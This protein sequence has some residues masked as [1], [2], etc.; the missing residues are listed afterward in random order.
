[1]KMGSG[2]NGARTCSFE[3]AAN[4]LQRSKRTVHTYVNQGF[5]RRITENGKVVLLLEDVEQLAVE[6]GTDTPALNRKTFF[7]LS[8]RVKKLEDEMNAVKH[9]LEI[10]DAPLRPSEL[11]AK[12]LYAAAAE[13]LGRRKWSID[14]MR[15]WAE[16]FERMDEVTLDTFRE[17]LGEPKPWQ[18]FYE[19]CLEMMKT[20]SSETSL[21]CMALHRKLDE[22]R[23]KMR[24]TI[25]MWIE[26]GRGSIP[27]NVFRLIDS[28]KESVLRKVSQ[29]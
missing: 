28:G 16:Q 20:L 26:M 15:L 27:D 14:E 12:G 23:K 29:G 9:I 24:A 5:I 4:R 13:S 18:L 3:F 11:E 2:N 8:S 10:R 22:G 1:M 6:L 25:V 19:L 21:E 17:A 7:Q